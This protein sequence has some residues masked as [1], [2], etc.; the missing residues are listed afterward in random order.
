MVRAG[1]TA[2]RRPR[3]PRPADRT[4]LRHRRRRRRALARDA[5]RREGEGPG[6]E[7]RRGARGDEPVRR[8]P[9]LAGL[10]AADD[11]AGATSTSATDFWSTPTQ[12]FDEYAAMG[13]TAVVCEEK[14]MGS[15]AV[16]VLARDEDAAERRFGVAD[17]STGTVYTR[18]GRPFFDDTEVM[19]DL[20]RAA[21]A[22]GAAVRRARDRLAGARLRAAAVVGQGARPDPRAVRRGR[23]GR[24]ARPA[25][26]SARRWTPRP[27]GAST[28]RTCPARAERR[29]DNARPSAT[30]T[31]RTAGRP[32]ASTA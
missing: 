5:V 32:T 16:A 26:R 23:R 9:A 12:A 27:P 20:R 4:A 11:V 7:R 22:D 21:A 29:L 14:H 30:P 8:R 25:G 18:T 31:R 2:G 15:R 1:P 24:P 10:P 17:G 19:A 28:S 13:V 6:R 3:G